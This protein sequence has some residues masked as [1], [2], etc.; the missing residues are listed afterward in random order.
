MKN[1]FTEKMREEQTAMKAW[2]KDMT[3]NLI[4]TAT[5]EQAVWY[6]GQL[7][8]VKRMFNVPGFIGA[9]GDNHYQSHA[10]FVKSVHEHKLAL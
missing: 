7:G 2:V 10:N 1:Y 9:A 6:N 5:T 4:K 3:N 8:E